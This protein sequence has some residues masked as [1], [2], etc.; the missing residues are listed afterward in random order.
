M[1]VYF[2]TTKP[3]KP[4]LVEYGLFDQIRVDYGKEWTLSLFVQESLAHLRHSVS[5]AAA[6][7][8]IIN[9]GNIP[10]TCSLLYTYRVFVKERNTF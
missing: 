3:Y 1:S 2:S 7:T 10:C 9:T 8:N 4:I 5:E 6:Q